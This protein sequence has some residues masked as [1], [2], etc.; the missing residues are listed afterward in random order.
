MS[1]ATHE[2]LRRARSAGLL[3]WCDGDQL[4]YRTVAGTIN[5]VLM[6]DLR[7]HD[8]KELIAAIRGKQSAVAPFSRY[9]NCPDQP[10]PL[11]GGQ[12][13]LFRAEEQAAGTAWFVTPFVYSSTRIDGEVG[14]E[15]LYRAVQAITA[16]HTALQT[17][18][19][20]DGDLVMQS[21]DRELPADIVYH[22]LSS[23][24][25]AWQAV[26][27]RELASAFLYSSVD[28][29]H[30]SPLRVCIVKWSAS[31]HWVVMSTPFLLS[32]W[33][34]ARVLQEDF[35]TALS[36]LIQGREPAVGPQVP[37]F[38]QYVVWKQSEQAA[39]HAKSLP[40][41]RDYLAQARACDVAGGRPRTAVKLL[42]AKR[43]PVSIGR[44]L[45]E[46]ASAMSHQLDVTP[47]VI[48]FAAFLLAI[49]Q[50][51]KERD[52]TVGVVGA[53]G[54]LDVLRMVGFCA[55]YAP[56]RFMLEEQTTCAKL[57]AEIQQHVVQAQEHYYPHIED[58]EQLLE[59][60]RPFCQAQFHFNVAGESALTSSE[61]G[62]A[63]AG[64]KFRDHPLDL[65]R[66]SLYEDLVLSVSEVP[67]GISA[68]LLHSD[69]VF[70]SGTAERFAGL[71]RALLKSVLSRQ[72]VSIERMLKLEA[73]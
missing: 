33:W 59:P 12:M 51:T 14:K 28:L 41:W 26:R 63:R 36:A 30:G 7:A 55:N 45:Y 42:L 60:P 2:L 35:V 53:R 31:R 62:H 16:Q 39:L 73:I 50:F 69:S 27:T 17:R 22:D 61:A 11:S 66:E 18:L 57:M 8:R 21:V 13:R 46:A 68:Y 25:D 56:M 65:E 4:R 37:Q 10:I 52:I 67:G 6:R 29:F 72:D 70:D 43:T 15:L 20:R 44:D 38:R 5:P 58:L 34:S 3:L 9:R 47:F 1:E 48:Y 23:V 49:A 71:Y 24:R 40:F 32:D 19:H 54:M 64:I